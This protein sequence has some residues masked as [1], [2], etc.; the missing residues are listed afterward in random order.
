MV[1]RPELNALSHTSQGYNAQLF[2]I[3]ITTGCSL[4]QAPARQNNQLFLLH[5]SLLCLCAFV[6]T[7]PSTWSALPHC[8]PCLSLNILLNTTSSMQP[9]WII[10]LEG[11]AFT[12]QPHGNL[13]KAIPQKKL[14]LL[15]SEMVPR[16]IFWDHG[17]FQ[18]ASLWGGG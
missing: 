17:N 5:T 3:I 1:C 15:C 10:M 13:S 12:S 18:R 6:N 16:I 9:S 14:N 11:L 7:F 2:E 8:K 4:P